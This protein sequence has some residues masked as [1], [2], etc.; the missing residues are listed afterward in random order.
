MFVMGSNVWSIIEIGPFVV[1]V[2]FI[3]TQPE[4]GGLAFDLPRYD[5]PTFVHNALTNDQPESGGGLGFMC[6]RYATPTG[7][8]IIRTAPSDT[9]HQFTR[10]FIPTTTVAEMP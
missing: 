10:V 2:L 5:T 7:N 9:S 3:K 4:A 8:V 1:S 6:V